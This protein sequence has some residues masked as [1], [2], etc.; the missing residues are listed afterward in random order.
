MK[1][2]SLTLIF[3]LFLAAGTAFGQLKSMITAQ[4]DTS[5]QTSTLLTPDMF[6]DVST[7]FNLGSFSTPAKPDPLNLSVL[8]RNVSK[9]ALHFG[10]SIL[11]NKNDLTTLHTFSPHTVSDYNRQIR[12]QIFMP[13]PTSQQWRSLPFFNW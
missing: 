6:F 5:S 3:T 9:V 11:A 8:D 1:T 10:R 7:S 4:A 13:E 2:V 12:Q